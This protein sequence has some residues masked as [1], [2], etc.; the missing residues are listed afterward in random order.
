MSNFHNKNLNYIKKITEASF[1]GFQ[2][3]QGIYHIRFI[4]DGVETF[5]RLEGT[6]D[7]ITQEGY[8][9]LLDLIIFGEAGSPLNR[10]GQNEKI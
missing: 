6:P 2:S 4:K 5:Y 8:K 7:D 10:L 3:Y 9:N 1:V